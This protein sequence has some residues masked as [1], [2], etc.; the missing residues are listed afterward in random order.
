MICIL[1]CISPLS[2]LGFFVNIHS[3]PSITRSRKFGRVYLSFFAFFLHF[4]CLSNSTVHHTQM[5]SPISALRW[6]FCIQNWVKRSESELADLISIW[7]YNYCIAALAILLA[8]LAKELLFKRALISGLLPWV[9]P[10]QTIERFYSDLRVSAAVTVDHRWMMCLSRCKLSK[11]PSD[12]GSSSIFQAFG[13]WR[14]W[15]LA[16]RASIE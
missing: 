8:L 2:K 16:S 7:W 15:S 6:L 9:F 10:E 13:W 12:L 5:N 14:R 4:S 1:H 3:S 11:R